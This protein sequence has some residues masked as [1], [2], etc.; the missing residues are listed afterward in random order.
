MPNNRLSFFLH[1]ELHGL[2]QQKSIHNPHHFLQ[3]RAATLGDPSAMIFNVYILFSHPPSLSLIFNLN[4]L[5]K[6]DRDPD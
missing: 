5:Q 2:L 4:D 1:V 3:P 6:A